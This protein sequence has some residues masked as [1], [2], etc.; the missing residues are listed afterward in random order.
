MVFLNLWTTKIQT[1]E[2][3][4]P[5]TMIKMTS[6]PMVSM[7]NTL[8]WNIKGIGSQGAI[9]RLN[10]FKNQNHSPYLFIQEPKVHESR[11]D[12]YKRLLTFQHCAHNIPN[13]IWIFCGDDYQLDILED[14]EQH[15]LIHISQAHRL[16]S[17]HLIIV[18][19]K[20][21]ETLK[22]ELRDNLRT[23]TNNINGPCGVVGDFNVIIEPQEK[24]GGRPFRFEES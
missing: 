12:K 17:F 13:K 16:I 1:A 21:E 4:T 19:A 3:Q 20:R 18:Y 5:T 14:K 8:S 24:S 11:I 15:M 10:L 9:E 23:T 2:F 7:I 6:T 22:R